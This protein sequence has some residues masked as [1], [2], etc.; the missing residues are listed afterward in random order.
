MGSA[1]V[2]PPEVSPSQALQHYSI[3]DHPYRTLS[4]VIIY[5]PLTLASAQPHVHC[6]SFILPSSPLP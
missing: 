1:K 6:K 5:D 2:R 4:L 3:T